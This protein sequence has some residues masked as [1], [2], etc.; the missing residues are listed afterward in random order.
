MDSFQK[1]I[2]ERTNLTA[3][4][5]FELLLFR[6]GS[7]AYGE[8]SELFGINVFKIREIVPMPPVTTAAGT[9][10]PMLGMVNIR[11]Q[12]IS[13]ID[14]PAVV[15]CVPKT[16]L[17]ILLV[18]EYARSTQAFAVESVDEIVRLEWSQVLSAESKTGGNFVTSI[19]RL[20][21]DKDAG[22]LAQVLDVEQILHEIMPTDRNMKMEN[23]GKGSKHGIKAGTVAIAADDSKV[24]RSLIEQGLRAMEIPFEMHITGAEAWAKIQKMAQEARSEG[25]PIT[26]K[27]SF[28][29]TDLEMPE[30]DGFTLTRNIK[31]DEFLKSLPVIIHSSLSGSTNEDHVKSVGADAYVGKFEANELAATIFGVLERASG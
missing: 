18:T 28:V 12:I 1:E 20:D 30:M 7:D 3:S 22:R 27:I 26:D 15:G 19:A 6:L 24:A 11:G 4:N 23:L 9:Q 17:N 14:L 16:G 25:R 5:K 10:S 31:R 8:R 2:D 13:V 29:L 21:A